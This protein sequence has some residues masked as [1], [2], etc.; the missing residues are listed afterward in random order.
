MLIGYGFGWPAET[1]LRLDFSGMSVIVSHLSNFSK[2]F[3]ATAR[4]IMVAAD[5]THQTRPR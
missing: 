4:F 1:P 5:S 2:C 3:R